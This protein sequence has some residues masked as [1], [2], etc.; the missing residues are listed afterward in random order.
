MKSKTKKTLAV[1]AIT[2]LASIGAIGPSSAA[3]N[4]GPVKAKTDRGI[5]MY[6]I[7]DGWCC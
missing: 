7:G 6:K 1:L 5:M 3:S 4:D 2:A